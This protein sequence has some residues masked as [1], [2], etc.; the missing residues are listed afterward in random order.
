MA[1]SKIKIKNF[2]I[3][4][5][6]EFCFNENINIIVGNNES[7]KSTLLEAIH[8][9]LT[10]LLDGKP[11][12]NEITEYLFNK[13]SID[14]YLYSLKTNDPL[15][16]PEI[17]IE[18]F[19]NKGAYPKAMGWF[20][21]DKNENAEGIVFSICFDD[22]FR[23]EYKALIAMDD[24]KTLPIE[25]YYVKWNAFSDSVIR[26]K[27]NPIKSVLIDSTSTRYRSGIDFYITSIIKNNL[28][29]NELVSVSQA[30]RKMREH[31]E[32]DISIKNINEKLKNI[33]N[34]TEKNIKISVEQLTRNAWEQSLQTC[35]NNIPFHHI[36]KG[37]QSVIKTNLALLSKKAINASIILIE[38][39]ENH[40]TYSRLN[41]LINTI[42]NASNGR[43]IVITTHSSFV[44]NKLG[45]NDI[46][47]LTH[48]V[49]TINQ[50]IFSK[51]SKDTYNYFKHISGYD[52][53]RFV[54]SKAI[55]LVEGPSDEL[56]VQKAYFQIYNKIPIHDCIDIRSVG[57]SFMRFL[58]LAELLNIKVAIVTD[59]DGRTESLNKKY[60]KYNNIKNICICYDNKDRTPE[61]PIHK[62]YNTLEYYLIQENGLEVI[63]EIIGNAFNNEEEAFSYMIENKTDCALRFFESRSNF[64]IPEY[65]Q[66][67][68]KHVTE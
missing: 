39:P 47:M 37:E 3:F 57:T 38:E 49:K 19:F 65:I 67:A 10:G 25:Y 1:L 46:I 35:I 34:V 7:G 14:Q 22:N 21:S 54:L 45:L 18:V 12:Y 59:N 17:V 60:N 55:I 4:E 61:H 29:N 2:K 5:Y 23:D 56:I 27:D 28:N 11:I 53:L 44:A 36:G 8:L 9:A 41:N 16:P 42:S 43:Q 66:K 40:L 24:V 6:F 15:P 68:I 58:E 13:N 62:N 31:F 64:N 63:S 50:T 30:H 20:N 52:T 26:S 48:G 51:L 33:P 32:D